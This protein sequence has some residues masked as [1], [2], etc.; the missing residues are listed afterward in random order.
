M[1]F[2]KAF[3]QNLTQQTNPEFEIESPI[4]LSDQIIIT[5]P[6]HPRRVHTNIQSDRII[7]I[8]LWILIKYIQCK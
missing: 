2:P 4:S 6:T 7:I 1:P 3:M 8:H 5:L